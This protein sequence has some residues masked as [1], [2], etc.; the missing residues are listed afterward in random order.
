MLMGATGGY[1]R[2]LGRAGHSVIVIDIDSTALAAVSN[3]YGG[4]HVAAARGE[5]LPF[6]PGCFDLVLSIQNFHTVDPDRA[7]RE[8]ARVLRP[9][10]R[11]GL[12][13]LTRDDSVPWVRKLKR[14][15]Q[16]ALPDAMS[17]DLRAQSIAAL[18]S[19]TC[20]SSLET[21]S[22]RLWVPST[23]EQLQDSARRA[24]GAHEAAEDHVQ[25]MVEAVGQLYDEY[26]RTPEPLMLPYEIRCWRAKVDRSGLTSPLSTP[27]KGLSISL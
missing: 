26:A 3:R 1:S 21:T 15:V 27:H 6:D 22:Y 16:E 5:N 20:F 7:L 11:I 13:Y 10:G 19:S 23:R 25:A 9:E 14:I 4:V 12:A 8:W 24:P 2:L 18:N 17:T